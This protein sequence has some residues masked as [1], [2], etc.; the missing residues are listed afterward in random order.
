MRDR[1]VAIA[2]AA[3]IGVVTGS[4]WAMGLSLVVGTF[5]AETWAD[6]SNLIWVAIPTFTVGAAFGALLGENFGW[7][8]SH[9]EEGPHV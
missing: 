4:L 9:K 5:R 7:L 8:S 1:P 3:F 6:P 2:V